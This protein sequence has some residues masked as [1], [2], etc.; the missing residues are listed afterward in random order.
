MPHREEMWKSDVKTEQS[1]ASH[2]YFRICKQRNKLD[3]DWLS[4]VS[5]H[6]VKVTTTDLIQ[7][8]RE[9]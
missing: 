9:Q 3:S 8:P 1:I 6:H 7:Y 2:E 4:R 5:D